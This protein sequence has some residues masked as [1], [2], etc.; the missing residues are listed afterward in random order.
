MFLSCGA[1]KTL[2]SPSDCKEIKP[3][4]PKGD[5]H[6]VFIGRTDAEAESPILWSPDEKNHSL[7]KILILQ[8]IEGKRRRRWHRTRW[9][10]GTSHSVD[11]TLNKLWEIVKDTGCWVL[12]P[13]GSQRV[14]YDIATKHQQEPLL[15]VCR[16]P[17]IWPQLHSPFLFVQYII[18]FPKNLVVKNEYRPRSEQSN[19]DFVVLNFGAWAIFPV[20]ANNKKNLQNILCSF[21]F[22]Y[23]ETETGECFWY[24]SSDPDKEQ[25]SLK[26]LK[27][28]IKK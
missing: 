22:F 12:Q 28:N 3:V 6:W 15:F 17:E 16:H 8:K 2:K 7:E 19:K 13:M 5:Q 1:A 9:L 20:V 4:N 23:S 26:E 18:V 10:D 24:S 27:I 21:F 14:R 25:C 11:I